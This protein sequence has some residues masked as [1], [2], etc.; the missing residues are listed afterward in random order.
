MEELE[1]V[2]L[3]NETVCAENEMNKV[4]VCFN[5]VDQ[6]QTGTVSRAELLSFL[7]DTLLLPADEAASKV[8]PITSRNKKLLTLKSLA[9][10]EIA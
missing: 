7:K 2:A 9:D 6:G 3:M 10:S 8:S 5:M 1:N 4:H